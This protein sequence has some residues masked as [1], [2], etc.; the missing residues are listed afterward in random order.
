[1]S[2]GPRPF[3]LEGSQGFVL[4]GASSQPHSYKSAKLGF[5]S[6]SLRE[7]KERSELEIFALH[8]RCTANRNHSAT[9]WKTS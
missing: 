5:N 9:V 2:R 3:H 8:L 7:L 1:M 6:N 4:H